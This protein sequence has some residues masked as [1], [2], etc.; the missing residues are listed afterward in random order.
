MK[1]IKIGKE[2]YKLDF[3]FNSFKFIEDLDLSTD[4]SKTP[5]K[6]FSTLSDLFYG[7]INCKRDKYIEREKSDELLEKYIETVDPVDLFNDL[8]ELISENHF[9]KKLNAKN[10][11][12]PQ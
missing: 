4:F 11:N 7:A 6:F 1:Q 12:D 9:F 10:E 2:N 5:F 8:V 3:T